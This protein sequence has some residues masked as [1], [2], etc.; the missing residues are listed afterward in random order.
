MNEFSKWLSQKDA[1]K[2]LKVDEKTLEILRE[3]GYF[4]PGFHWKSS[5][6]PGQLPW[7]PKV[8]YHIIWCREVIDNLNNN[9]SSI[10][11]IAA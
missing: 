4:K 2:V 1:V 3:K 11:Q 5:T 7:N 9:D 10:A 8:F 6:E